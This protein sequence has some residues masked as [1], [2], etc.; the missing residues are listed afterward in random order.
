[1]PELPEVESYR[2]IAERAIGRRISKVVADDDWYLKRDTTAHLLEVALQDSEFVAS[3]RVGKLLL[4]DVRDGGTVGLHFGMSG[5][6]LVDEERGVERLI[7]SSHRVLPE[8]DRFSVYFEDGGS[9]RLNDS[10]RLGGVELDPDRERLGTDALSLTLGT[11][12]RVLST[13][14][15]PLKARLMDQE[16]IAGVGNL[17]ADEALWRAG[18]DPARASNSLD[19]VEL[20][21]LQRVLRKTINDLILRG[22]S[23]TGDLMEAR[24]VGGLCP[25]DG[26]PLLRRQVGGRTTYSCP[27]H[28]L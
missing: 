1:M 17:I 26:A 5:T 9:M 16:R 3:R 10:R 23:H 18:L 28:Q 4:L 8:W 15:A 2:R 21:R 6:L 24:F 20:K 14:T 12:R 27:K 7:Y 13:S 19:D 25:K 22:G 11:L